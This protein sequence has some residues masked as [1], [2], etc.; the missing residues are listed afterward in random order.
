M[1]L[2]ERRE[3][4]LRQFMF[5]C[6]CARCTADLQDEVAG[7]TGGGGQTGLAPVDVAAHERLVKAQFDQARSLW[8]RGGEGDVQ[9]GDSSLTQARVLL[10]QVVV[11]CEQQKANQVLRSFLLRARDTLGS[12]LISLGLFAEARDCLLEYVAGARLPL[13]TTPSTLV[14]VTPI[15]ANAVHRRRQDRRSNSQ[16]RSKASLTL[17]MRVLDLSMLEAELGDGIASEMHAKD[18]WSELVCLAGEAGAGEIFAHRAV[19]PPQ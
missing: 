15:T 14:D 1:G 10:E 12:V 19:S 5:S 16:I 11:R 13:H 4:L 18:A 3:E 7:D 17:A 8:L 6:A 9:G 2:R